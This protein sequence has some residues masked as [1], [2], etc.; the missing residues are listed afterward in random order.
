MT[1]IITVKS[2][3]ISYGDKISNW[4][5]IFCLR[6]LE[7]AKL[8]TL[9]VHGLEMHQ[10]DCSILTNLTHSGKLLVFYCGT[11]RVSHFKTYISLFSGQKWHSRPS[12]E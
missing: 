1:Y 11:N 2:V 8:L 3:L 10:S 6:H 5:N 9:N 12:L 7:S 4:L